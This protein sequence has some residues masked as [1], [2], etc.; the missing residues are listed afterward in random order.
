MYTITNP[1]SLRLNVHS[2]LKTELVKYLRTSFLIFRPK[3]N[4]Q[5]PCI[6]WL[7]EEVM[8]LNETE[9]EKEP[10][11]EPSFFGAPPTSL[12]PKNR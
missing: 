5:T 6:A 9:N 1:S 7:A 10:F 12:P 3:Y 4:Y 8:G 11:W 2:E